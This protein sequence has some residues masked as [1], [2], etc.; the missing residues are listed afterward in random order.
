MKSKSLLFLKNAGGAGLVI[1]I[2]TAAR[3]GLPDF[4]VTGTTSFLSDIPATV[5]AYDTN[6]DGKLDASELGS[7]SW[8]VG[9]M[10]TDKD[11]ALTVA[12][13]KAGM[14]KLSRQIF[15]S[16]NAEPSQSAPP[17]FEAAKDPRQGPRPLKPAEWAVDTRIPDLE[18]QTLSGEQRKLHALTGPKGAVVAV[19]CPECPVSRRWFPALQRLEKESMEKGV[20]FIFIAAPG[21]MDSAALKAAGM[22]GVIVKDPA[23][24]LLRALK[25]TRTT[26]VFVLDAAKTLIYRG[27]PDDQYG[28]G[29]SRPEPEQKYLSKALEA[30]VK[31]SRPAIAATL[32]PG[33]ELELPAA[34]AVATA[35]PVTWHNRVS[36]MV[37]ANCASCHHEGGAG[38]FPLET[39]PQFLKK[40]KTVRR[41]LDDGVMP[42][43]SAA[44][45][46]ESAHTPWLNESTLPAADKAALLAWLDGDRAEGDAAEAPLP[47]AWARE[48][49]IEAPDLTLRL[50]TPV[51]VQ[52]EGT[53]PY[54]SIFV[55]T[56]LTEDKWVSSWEVIPSVRQ[57]VHHVL[58]Y[59]YPP[60]SGIPGEPERRGHLASWVPGQGPAVYPPGYAKA[61][62][63][64]SRLRFEIH[65][66]PSGKAVE[67][68]TRLELKFAPAPPEYVVESAGVADVQLN[69]P[70]GAAAHGEAAEWTAPADIH[71][72]ALSPHMHV[73]GKSMR[74]EA[75]QPGGEPRL[76]LEVPRY[77]FNWQ[78]PVKYAEPPMLAKGSVIK[79]T[80]WFDNSSG[81]PANPD[82]GVTVHWGS[83]TNDEMM[84]G[85]V[86]YCRKR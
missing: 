62:P 12:E 37:Q 39:Y 77:D 34:P 18:V 74:F 35:T 73:R 46:A 27:A 28:L 45:V 48:G 78:I 66:T 52:A 15:T 60:G 56:G 30:L 22:A 40:A 59:V 25:A 26:D 70:P 1:A 44:P 16:R 17:P 47:I 32:A 43:W 24:Q 23:G 69:I 11:G 83:Q 79:V 80:G 38:P 51:K 50:P 68:Q 21:E 57:A 13:M 55:D 9:L 76:L 10:D 2:A 42:P 58:I 65:Y 7:R 29:Y 5:A 14:A 31:G 75:K 20:P 84:I 33:C 54:Q 81:N 85:Y 36:R 82:P 19:L 3:A 86:E 72:L 64:G 6:K 61:L 41:V 8:M 63:A 53:M 4:S 67:D 71:L 49:A